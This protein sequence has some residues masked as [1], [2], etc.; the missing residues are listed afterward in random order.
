MKEG[1]A[2]I[3]A[4][5]LVIAYL[6][7]FRRCWLDLEFPQVI[8]QTGIT[9]EGS[10]Q[11]RIVVEQ[12]REDFIPDKFEVARINVSCSC[13]AAHCFIVLLCSL[14]AAGCRAPCGQQ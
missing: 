7:L 6:N 4:F 10:Y 5:S 14:W 3:P 9:R 2:K 11:L 12:L 1:L 8:E 13:A